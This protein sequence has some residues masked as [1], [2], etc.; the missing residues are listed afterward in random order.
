MKKDVMFLG[1]DAPLT[2][3]QKEAL[4]AEGY[5]VLIVNPVGT[6]AEIVWAPWTQPHPPPTPKKKGK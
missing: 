2:A 3:E 4:E 5:I 1:V 6:K